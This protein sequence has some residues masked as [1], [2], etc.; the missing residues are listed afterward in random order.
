[1]SKKQKRRRRFLAR[2]AG[3]ERWLM[4]VV[5][6]SDLAEW[7]EPTA[8]RGIRFFLG[9]GALRVIRE[10]LGS[11]EA[12]PDIMLQVLY[13]TG[14]L[15]LVAGVLWFVSANA[16]PPTAPVP[17]PER[18]TPRAARQS[19]LHAMIPYRER[20]AKFRALEPRALAAFQYIAQRDTL[21]PHM[22]RLNM[23]PKYLP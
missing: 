17:N 4:R 18:T 12:F 20:V 10:G 19:L 14:T 5:L 15:L 2:L 7:A 16:T 21:M 11:M 22:L 3:V 23:T 6:I 9:G 8:K 1:M 13:W